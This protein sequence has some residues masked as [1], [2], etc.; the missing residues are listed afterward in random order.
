MGGSDIAAIWA[1]THTGQLSASTTRRRAL[2]LHWRSMNPWCTDNLELYV[3]RCYRAETGRQ[4]HRSRLYRHRDFPHLAV[5]P[6]YE[7]RGERPLRL[8]ECKTTGYFAGQI[9]GQPGEVVPEQDPRAVHGQLA[10]TRRLVCDLAVLIGGQDF[11]IYTIERDE[12]LIT[13]LIERAHKFWC[14]F[15]LAG[16]PP[17]LTGR[18]P[19]C[20]WVKDQHPASTEE[21]IYASPEMDELCKA[22]REVSEGVKALGRTSPPRKRMQSLHARC[23]IDE[24][25]HRRNNLALMQ[26]RHAAVQKALQGMSRVLRSRRTPESRTNGNRTGICAKKR[27]CREYSSLADEPAFLAG[28]HREKNLRGPDVLCLRGP[29]YAYPSHKTICEE[30]GISRRACIAALQEL[31]SAGFIRCI[32]LYHRNKIWE[33]LWHAC[34]EESVRNTHT[35]KRD[36]VRDQHTTPQSV[37]FNRTGSG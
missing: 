18:E 7:I 15:V 23:R 12:E 30:C 2:P 29:T 11:R 14:D 21:V 36:N 27:I 1:W 6:G 4:I 3:A 25:R 9:F 19:D 24:D 5:N 34:F 37:P 10:I 28:R 26:E 17:P 33:F 35:S 20:H 8:L 32:G 22:L 31:E 16:C 13:A